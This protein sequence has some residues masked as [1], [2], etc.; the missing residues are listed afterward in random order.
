VKYLVYKLLAR[1]WWMGT[2][3]ENTKVMFG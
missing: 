1:S 3:C 2:R